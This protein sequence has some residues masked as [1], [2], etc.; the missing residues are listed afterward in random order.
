M[1]PNERKGN[2]SAQL[3]RDEKLTIFVDKKD[4]VTLQTLVMNL[5]SRDWGYSGGLLG[6]N[7]ELAKRGLVSVRERAFKVS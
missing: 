7:S 4:N 3:C 6:F 5:Q 1:W 2:C